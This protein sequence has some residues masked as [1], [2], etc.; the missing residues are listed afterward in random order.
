MDSTFVAA[1]LGSSRP[2]DA[3]QSQYEHCFVKHVMHALQYRRIGSGYFECPGCKASFPVKPSTR[4]EA[5]HLAKFS[6][7]G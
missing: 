6:V 2:I 4:T 1:A 3:L 5:S 7:E